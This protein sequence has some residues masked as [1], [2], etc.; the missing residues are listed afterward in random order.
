MPA[1]WLEKTIVELHYSITEFLIQQVVESLCTLVGAGAEE[2][3]IAS[4][5]AP[6]QYFAHPDAGGRVELLHWDC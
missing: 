3:D 1:V 2:W 4:P 5:P 6:R